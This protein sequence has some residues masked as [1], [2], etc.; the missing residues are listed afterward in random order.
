[1]DRALAEVGLERQNPYLT[2]AVNHF[3]FVIEGKRRKHHTRV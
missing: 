3:K 2:N 1:L